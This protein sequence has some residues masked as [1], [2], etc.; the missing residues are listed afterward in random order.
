[1]ANDEQKQPQELE[2]RKGAGIVNGNP[3]QGIYIQTEN[4]A[5]NK[6][7]EEQLK[8]QNK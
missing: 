1:M 4:L 2:A 7:T 3:V 6:V 5:T 8:D